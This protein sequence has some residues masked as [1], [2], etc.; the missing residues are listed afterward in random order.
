[1]NKLSC[2]VVILVFMILASGISQAGQT[3]DISNF[4]IAQ[5][6]A[7]NGSQKNNGQDPFS[8]DLSGNTLNL[9]EGVSVLNSP[10]ICGVCIRNVNASSL[11][12]T[13]NITGNIANNNLGN[14]NF[15]GC[16][17]FY[18]SNASNNMVN[19]SDGITLSEFDNVLIA[20]AHVEGPN[21]DSNKVNISGGVTITGVTRLD[22]YG[23][24]LHNAEM[25]G[26]LRKQMY[27]NAINISE[28]VSFKS[29]RANKH[30]RCVWS[31]YSHTWWFL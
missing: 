16:Y 1:M 11:N 28:N 13:L 9:G 27:G 17:S 14:P 18:S 10:Y 2:F 26:D 29:C 30:N 24:L 7:G 21:V 3:I 31:E 8:D 4:D 23:A 15:C 19:I 12:N 6:T 20:G 5:T 25:T 22:I